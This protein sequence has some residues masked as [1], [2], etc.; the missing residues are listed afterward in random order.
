MHVEK[1]ETHTPETLNKRNGEFY[2]LAE[3]YEVA[4]YEGMGVGPVPK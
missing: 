4:S 3:K 1:I 2:A